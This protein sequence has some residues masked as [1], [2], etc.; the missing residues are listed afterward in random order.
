MKIAEGEFVFHSDL[1]QPM[2]SIYEEPMFL[3]IEACRLQDEAAIG[4]MSG[5]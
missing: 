4:L 1:Q 3:L 5:S 2:Q